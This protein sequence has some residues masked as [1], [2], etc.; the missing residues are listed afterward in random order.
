LLLI[1][2]DMAS[3]KDLVALYLA[4][5]DSNQEEADANVAE[6]ARRMSSLCSDNRDTIEGA[7]VA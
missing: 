7:Q 6:I 5:A 3:T 1:F 2:V 4:S